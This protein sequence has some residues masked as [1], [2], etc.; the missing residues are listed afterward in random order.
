MVL[1]E[2][3]QYEYVYDH[4]NDIMKTVEKA[5]GAAPGEGGKG[6][7]DTISLVLVSSSLIK[8]PKR[9]IYDNLLGLSLKIP[10]SSRLCFSPGYVLYIGNVGEVNMEDYS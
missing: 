9:N 2:P 6:K 3:V 10:D 5:G 7:Q 4:E 8:I 1:V